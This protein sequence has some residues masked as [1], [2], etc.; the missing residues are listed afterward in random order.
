MTQHSQ[1]YKQAGV[2][3]EAADTLV[4]RIKSMAKST[5]TRGVVK[6]IGSF[7]GMFR[8][9]TR[10]MSNPVLVSSTDGVGTKLKLAFHRDRHD[11][12]GVDLVAMNVNDIAVHGAKPLFFMDY[13][14]TSELRVDQAERVVSG[15]AAGC[16]EAGC[17][18]LGG[19]TA[20]VPGFYQSG[21]YELSGFAVGLV[22][23]Q[24]IVDGSGIG[25]G[26]KVI[27]LASN[28]V[29]A[30]GFSLV[31]KILSEG[32]HSL[33]ETPEGLDR[34]LGDVLLDPTRIYVRTVQNLLRDFNIRGI[35]HVTG[36]GLYDNI[37]RVLPR[38]VVADLE[39]SSWSRPPIFDWLKDQAEISW[40]EMLKV[41]NCGIGLALVVGERE[42]ED[43]MLRLR[44][45][46]E[47]AWA[48]GEIK[49]ARKDDPSVRVSF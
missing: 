29:H 33:D 40:E 35:V 31:R 8:L 26:N 11:T 1:A 21:E 4:D 24:R 34:P 18:L 37:P 22:D 46:R 7:G 45:L 44:G 16:R 28:G 32:G 17:A 14:A 10:G 43:V 36:G 41:F 15:I 23:D 5:H 2:D 48:I 25:V 20:E 39:F 9:N 47:Q 13:Y 19:E 38:G 6:D 42:Y 12:V 30:N 49:A 27:G 3:I